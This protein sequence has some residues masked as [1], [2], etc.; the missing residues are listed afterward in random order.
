MNDCRWSPQ[1]ARRMADSI[2][3]EVKG[4]V[5]TSRLV[6]K[7]EGVALV[8]R[9]ELEVGELLG[10][11]A[12]SEVHEVRI[13]RNEND[14]GGNY[15]SHHHQQ[16]QQPRFAMKHLKHKLM[17]QPDNFRLAAAELAVEAHMLASFDHPNIL[18]IRGWSANGVASFTSGRHD[19]FFLLLDRLDETLDQR[20]VQW[21]RI[22]AV[23]EAQAAQISTNVVTDLWRRFAVQQ[24]QQQ[25]QQQEL[26]LNQQQQH[27][28]LEKLGVC[29]DIASALSYLH[30][31]GVIFR[32]LKPNNI[33][34][35]N[36]R[37]QLFDFGLSRE[38]PGQDLQEP[39]EMSGKVGTLRYMAVEVAC[40]SRY[41]VSAD[42]YSWAMVSYET[43]TLQKPFSGWTRDM[44]SNLVCGRGVRP[45]TNT[46]AV[47]AGLLGAAGG[48]NHHYNSNNMSMRGLL[49]AAWNQSPDNRPSMMQVCLSMQSIE[50]EQLH[51][52]SIL[53]EQSQ[54][55]HNGHPE[56]AEM[57]VELP[58]D[59]SM[60]RKVPD[61][62]HSALSEAFTRS[63]VSTSNE[64]FTECL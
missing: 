30:E 34:F 38:L 64:S 47:A 26:A 56:A 7:A 50:E 57:V 12:F 19:S 21:Q 22:Q 28:Y 39:F 44:H 61:R 1:V 24:Q 14:G 60:V 25:Q 58:R 45:E 6:R 13:L 2:H 20:I 15:N 31:R 49:E 11:G 35:L 41:N 32:D 51:V 5:A 59:F 46:T 53:L 16:Q 23:H 42:V 43:L 10:R 4:M 9:H 8:Q 63:T 27:L 33:G 17:S 18:K 54:E 36:G 40:H 29:S 55:Y 37:V 48:N 3:A 52:A 62:T